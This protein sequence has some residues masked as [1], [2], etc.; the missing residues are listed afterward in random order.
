MVIEVRSFTPQRIDRYLGQALNWRS[1]ARLQRV[2]REGRVSVNGETA[3][4]SRKVRHGDAIVLELSM[5]VGMPEDYSRLALEVI[6]EDRWLV[7]VN[8]PPG[9]LVHP[10]GRH[11]YDTLINH[12]HHRYRSGSEGGAR[13]APGAEG[14]IVPRLCHRIDRETTGVVLVAKDAHVHREVQDQFS[15]RLVEKEYIALVDGEF[16]HESGILAMPIGEGRCLESC[17]EHPV[18]KESFTS[19]RVLERLDGSTLL[20]C[21]PR[22]GRQ[23]QIRVHLAAAGHPI[24]GDVRY[25]GS[26]PS[27]GFPERFLLHSRSLILHHPRLKARLE[28]TAPLP[29]DFRKLI[30]RLRGGPGAG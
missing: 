27:A 28:L 25:G 15:K 23:N 16:R 10:V 24:A 8:K 29:E 13:S 11:V 19:V 30:E 9:L 7:A 5:G 14:E 1:R 22:T 26:R 2:I 17:L 4:P 12:L 18:L 3:K 6:Y 21:V 20:A